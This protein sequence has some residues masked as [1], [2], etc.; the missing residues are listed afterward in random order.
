MERRAGVYNH[1]VLAAAANPA[2]THPL[3]LDTLKLF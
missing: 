1:E 3:P 2:A